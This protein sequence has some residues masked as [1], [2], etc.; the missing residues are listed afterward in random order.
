V[1]EA[2]TEVRPCG[3]ARAKQGMVEVTED[4]GAFVYGGGLL[5]DAGAASEDDEEV[6]V[7]LVTELVEPD[8]PRQ[9]GGDCGNGGPIAIG[10]R[11]LGAPLHKR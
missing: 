3:L 8:V 7:Y 1:G 11:S 4:V 10:K 2:E 5:D 9:G 6:G